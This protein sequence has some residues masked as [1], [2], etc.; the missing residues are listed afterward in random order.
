MRKNRG[1]LKK[2]QESENKMKNI[3]KNK[4]LKLYFKNNTVD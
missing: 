2:Q 1:R 4:K 3:K